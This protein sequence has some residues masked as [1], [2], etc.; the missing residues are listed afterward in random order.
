MDC[1]M[2]GFPVLHYLQEFIHTHVHWACDAIQPFHPQ[3]PLLLPSILPSIRVFSSESVLCIMWPKYWNFSFSISPSNEYSGLIS[4]RMDWLDL[5]AVQEILKSLLQH[6]S[7]KASIFPH[8]AFSTVQ[9]GTSLHDYWKNHS[10]DCTICRHLNHVQTQAP[11]LFRLDLTPT[12]QKHNRLPTS[13][14]QFILLH[15]HSTMEESCF[16]LIWANILKPCLFDRILSKGWSLSLQ[17]APWPR[18]ESENI[19]WT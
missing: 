14:K 6:N 9:F 18:A 10:F 17:A 3:L 8:S 15:T 4:F 1:S 12:K 2:P 13:R 11:P 7:S 5:L 19:V 16:W